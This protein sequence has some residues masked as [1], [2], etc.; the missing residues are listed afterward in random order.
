MRANEFLF[1]SSDDD[2]IIKDFIDFAATK[3]DLDKLP[4]IKLT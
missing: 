4:K 3:L 2:S 1:E